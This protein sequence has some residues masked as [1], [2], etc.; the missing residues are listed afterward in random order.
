[1]NIECLE[2]RIAP[3]SLTFNDIDGDLVTITT[4][5]GSANDLAGAALFTPLQDGG[6]LLLR[7]DLSA[8]VFEGTNLTVSAKRDPILGGDGFV[9]LG[10][11]YAIGRDL[12]AVMIDG[13]LGAID[14]GNAANPAIGMKSLTVQSFGR[15]GGA[16]GAP[17]LESN[18]DGGLGKLTVKSDVSEAFVNVVDTSGALKGRIG[19]V[20]IGGSLIGGISSGSGSL[21]GAH[22]LGPVKIGGDVV[23]GAG[24][25]S[26][27]VSA[28]LDI[29]SVTIG[30]TV[31]GGAGPSSGFIF[32]S[33]G[34][35]GAVKIGGD[36]VGGDAI[37]SGRV[38]GKTSIASILVKG[39]V[40]GTAMEDTG[41]IHSDGAIGAVQINGDL[42]GGG[43]FNAGSLFGQSSL[44]KVTIR[45]SMIGGTFNQTGAV[46]SGGAIKSVTIG[47]SLV[48]GSGSGGAVILT[49]DTIGPVKITG[50]MIGMGPLTSSISGGEIKSVSV[51]GSIL[52]GSGQ[53]SGAIKS[54]PGGIGRVTVGVDVRGGAGGQS[55][56][57][58]ST[59]DLGSI[60]IGGTLSGGTANFS[61][62]ISANF[63]SIGSVKIGGDIVGADNSGVSNLFGSGYID[64]GRI[65]SILVKGSIRAGID[66]GAG[67]LSQNAMITAQ[68]GIGR[69]TVL[70]SL[71]GAA[72]TDGDSADGD[73]T[74]VTISA[75]GVFAQAGDTKIPL[76]IGSVTVGGRVENARILAGYQG[77]F[78]APSNGDAQIG[79]ISVG[80]DWIAS[81]IA[82]GTN[83]GADDIAGTD[84]DTFLA[85]APEIPSK[86]ASI[87]IKGQAYGTIGSGDSFRFMAERIGKVTI[88]STVFPLTSSANDIRFSSTLDVRIVDNG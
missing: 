30:G 20:I 58:F 74:H 50:D 87:T 64:G 22:G 34:K 70:G 6:Q 60:V 52:G 41:K 5:K 18:I 77:V 15:L 27:A 56:V 8:A 63:G 42:E 3:A 44:G 73:F 67:G 83:D 16:Y 82:A 53:D 86:I 2:S 88:G 57:I 11:V 40:T 13:D 75:L 10:Y 49:N 39:S 43:G 33:L 21:Y 25:T 81:R 35:L 48:G 80:G 69:V 72:H 47:G 84:D 78:L 45:G 28:D 54:N 55:G 65:G 46:L 85:G 12:G 24:V 71:I 31:S 38:F 79:R 76:T 32:S 9:S 4:S 62:G 37:N 51:G 14:A 68:D 23:G 29:A 59:G 26:G 17:D 66:S 61:G 1:M 7:L 19:S 36:L